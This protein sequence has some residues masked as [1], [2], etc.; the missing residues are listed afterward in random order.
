MA[1]YENP[2][3]MQSLITKIP[4]TLIKLNLHDCYFIS[5]SFIAKLTDLQELEFNDNDFKDFEKLQYVIFPRLQILKFR[6]TCPKYELLIKFLENNG[7][8]LKEFYADDFDDCSD[9]SFN[10]AISKFCPNLR[11]LSVGFKNYELETLKIVLNSCQY[12][13]SIN[14]WCGENHLAEK[15][16][17]EIIANYSSDHF[18]ELKICNNH[19]NLNTDSVYL[20]DLEPFFIIWKNR[21]SRKLLRL[22]LIDYDLLNEETMKIIEK[23]ENLGIIKFETKE[24]NKEEYEEE[25]Y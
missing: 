3:N 6:Y 19:H 18:Y 8:N 15:E 10:L 24:H 11:K 20:K 23:Y 25:M 16:V 1:Q 4:N 2:K 12:L 21:T 22:M 7:K 5:L 9:N 14:I 17:L 13:E